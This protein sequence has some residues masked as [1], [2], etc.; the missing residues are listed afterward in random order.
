MKLPKPSLKALFINCGIAAALLFA[1][2]LN[3]DRKNGINAAL[4]CN[5]GVSLMYPTEGFR[6]PKTEEEAVP[7][8]TQ[9]YHPG[10]KAHRYFVECM[11]NRGFSVAITG[12]CVGNPASS[13]ITYAAL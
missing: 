9:V 5:Y 11:E 4:V 2:H 1:V 13:C 8:F 3:I 12:D 7:L 10:S 6:P